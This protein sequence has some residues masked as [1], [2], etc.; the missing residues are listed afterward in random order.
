VALI[1]AILNWRIPSR[2][3]MGSLLIGFGG[4]VLL[5]VPTLASGVPADLWS[6]IALLVAGLS[7][8]CGL[9]LQ[10][11]NPVS[12]AARASSGYQQVIAGLGF[13][14]VAL[15]LREPHPDPAPEAWL[16]WAYLV[17]FGSVLAFTSF[18]QAVRLLPVSL[19]TTYA[20]VNPV[21]AVILGWLILR[22]PITGWTLGGA[23]LVLLG[24]AGVF[25]TRYSETSTG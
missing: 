19:A 9:V 25:R 1:E 21:I 5:T 16:A 12:L 8:G 17:I 20:Y 2:L 22:E 7:W 13:A 4:I 18:V 11:R 15:L 23:V 6:L 24:V 10:S 3:L 14:V